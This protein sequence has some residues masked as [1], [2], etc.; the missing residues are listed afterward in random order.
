MFPF[1]KQR[2]SEDKMQMLFNREPTNCDVLLRST[3]GFEAK[4]TTVFSYQDAQ[5]RVRFQK[6]Q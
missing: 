6:I 2:D 1:T 4:V 5:T 3:A